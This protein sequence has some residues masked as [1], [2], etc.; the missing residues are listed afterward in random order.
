M[1]RTAFLLAAIF[2]SVSANAGDQEIIASGKAA[3]AAKLIEPSS[4]RF[5]DAWVKVGR[6]GQQFVCGH[7]AAKSRKGNEDTKA[8]VFIPNE[9][10]AEHSAII[11]NGRSITHDRLS[12]FADP[13]A[14]NDFCG[15]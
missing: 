12:A 10:H 5:P 4:A 8:F 7:V 15:E 13:T 2:L 6:N 1:L 11:Y 14:F 3:V 9:K